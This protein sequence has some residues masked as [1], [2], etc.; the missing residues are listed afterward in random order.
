MYQINKVFGFLVPANKSSNSNKPVKGKEIDFSNS[1]FNVVAELLDSSTTKCNI[2]IKFSAK[3]KANGDKVQ[4]NSFKP[5]LINL[6]KSFTYENA[7]ICAEKLSNVTDGTSKDSILFI[8]KA[9][10]QS[11]TRY[12]ISRIPAEVGITITDDS[13]NF[14]FSVKEDVFI[15]SS[16][17]YKAVY[18]DSVDEFNIGYAV[19]KQIQDK[20]VSDYWLKDFLDSELNITPQRASKQIAEAFKKTIKETGNKKI[21]AELTTSASLIQNMNTNM[22]NLDSILNDFH[23]S[24]ETKDAVK[25]NLSGIS[26]NTI[27][28]LDVSEFQKNFNYQI[29]VLDSGAIAGGYAL[30]FNETWD[31]EED[32]SGQTKLSTKGIIKDTKISNNKHGGY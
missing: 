13:S 30:N 16:K 15:K 27:F 26:S 32:A 29:V 1:S 18:Y 7:L 28:S 10:D 2:E 22:T 3:T 19:D 4:E 5:L 17:K 12:L 20:A 23:L 25:K 24:S 31:I 21:V 6:S 14:D 11:N 9:T 8:V